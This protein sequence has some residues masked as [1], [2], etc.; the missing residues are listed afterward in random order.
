MRF[1]FRQQLAAEPRLAHQFLL[2]RLERMESRQER[3]FA[4]LGEALRLGA[5]RLEQAMRLLFEVHVTVGKTHADVL[6]IKAEQQRQGGR[7]EAIYELVTALKQRLDLQAREVRPRDSFS[8]RSESDRRQ[9]DEVLARFRELSADQ[10]QAS[11]ALVNSL[12]QLLVAQGNFPMAQKAFEMVAK[13]A[14]AG[15]AKAQASFNGFRAALEMK[16]WD[17]A[18]ALARQ[19]AELDP[20]FSLF[21]SHKYEPVRVLGAG[22][23]GVTF[24]CRHVHMG[25]SVVVKSLFTEMLERD[26]ATVFSEAQALAA[27]HHPGII[28]IRDCGFTDPERR[29]RPYLVMD[30]FDGG[31]LED[32]VAET[33]PLTPEQLL[34]LARQVAEALA[35]AHERGVF[36]RDVKPANLLVRRRGDGSLDSRLIDF[37]LALQ[38]GTAA[39][40]TTMGRTLLGASIAGTLKYAAPEQMGEIA[41]PIGPYS[42]VYGFGRTCWFALFQTPEPDDDDKETLPAEWRR[43]L[44]ACSSRTP[45]KRPQDFRAVLERLAELERAAR[46]APAEPAPVKPVEPAPAPRPEAPPATA[47]AGPDPAV[48]ANYREGLGLRTEGDAAD[49]PERRRRLHKKAGAAFRKAANAGHAPAQVALG[50][51]YADGLGY[52]QDDA[53]AAGWFRRAAKNGL[54]EGRYRFGLALRDGVGVEPDAEKADE[55]LR[56]AFAGFLSRAEA[57][58]GSACFPLAVMY[59]KRLGTKRDLKAAAVW[60]RK[61]A[62]AGNAEARFWIGVA[63]ADGKIPG[64]PRDDGEAFGWFSSAAGQGHRDAM[65]RLGDMFRDGVGTDKDPARATEWYAKA[66]ELGSRSA[67]RRLNQLR[68]AA[69]TGPTGPQPRAAAVPEPAAAPTDGEEEVSDSTRDNVTWEDVLRAADG[70]DEDAPTADELFAPEKGATE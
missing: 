47:Q 1:F 13:V 63:C 28:G 40:S 11:P 53:T 14:K 18:A 46:P 65:V 44:A 67:S 31:T 50:E 23:F 36:H 62:E 70:A 27:V 69:A 33:A 39:P 52:D 29:E 12:G 15:P 32:L 22:G 51:L 6:D 55:M 38:P 17:E 66:A 45:A 48:E 7:L 21:H 58:D 30:F 34:P 43:F 3:G 35:A 64:V 8:M 24:L 41:A 60:Y 61:A 2:E 20:R 16:K 57:G 59:E 4:A 19:A 9:L 49:D 42:D 54:A 68:A 10:R 26:V 25:V 5:D 37:G 56:A